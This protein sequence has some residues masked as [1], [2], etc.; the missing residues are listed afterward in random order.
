MAILT[1]KVIIPAGV[2][3]GAYAAASVTGDSF[4]ASSDQR[5]ML[6]VK[7]GGV[8]PITVTILAQ[9]AFE[10]VPNVGTIAVANLSGPVANAGDAFFGPFPRDFIGANGQVQVTYSAVTSV[11]VAVLSLPKAD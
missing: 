6:H 9:T 3:T 8:A 7:N 5:V 4:P 2:A 1:P 10:K 11:T